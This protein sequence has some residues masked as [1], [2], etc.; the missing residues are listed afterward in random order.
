MTADI[1]LL[2]VAPLLLGLG[3][4]WMP[5]SPRWL[6]SRDQDHKAQKVLSDLHRTPGDASNSAAQQEYEHIRRQ[7]RAEKSE[8]KGLITVLKVPSYRKRFLMG[9]FV[10]CLAQSTGVSITLRWQLQC[11]GLIHT[12]GLGHKQLPGPSIQLPWTV[13]VSSSYA[14]RRVR[15][16]CRLLELGRGHGR[17]QS[18]PD[19]HAERWHCKFHMH[20]KFASG[21]WHQ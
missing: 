1:Y 8:P 12:P 3:T 17:R 2:V 4:P 6:I 19:S 7:L 5:E 11:T 15:I 10:Q 21:C 9:L 16:L 18:G 14:L 20:L 13:W